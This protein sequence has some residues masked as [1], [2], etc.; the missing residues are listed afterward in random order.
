MFSPQLHI[1]IH[2][3]ATESTAQSRQEGQSSAGRNQTHT[4]MAGLSGTEAVQA[5]QAQ[6][7]SRQASVSQTRADSWTRAHGVF[8]MAAAGQM[9]SLSGGLVPTLSLGRAWQTKDDSAMRLTDLVPYQHETDGYRCSSLLRAS[10]A[11][12]CQLTLTWA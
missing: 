7:V 1:Y 11:V 12:N 6:S 4:R 8:R 9:R 5:G 3:V 10:R 2:P